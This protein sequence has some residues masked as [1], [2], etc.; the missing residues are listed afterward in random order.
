MVST[1]FAF[2]S[3]AIPYVNAQP[4]VGFAFEAVL[5]D[6]IARYWRARGRDVV[7]LSGTDDNSL[8]NVAAARARG[9][10]TQD[11]V[12]ENGDHFYALRAALELSYDDFVRTSSDLRHRSAV[13]KLWR[14]CA[15]NGDIYLQDYS[16]LYCAGCEQF[17]APEELIDGVCPEHGITPEQITEKNYFFRLSRYRDE[18][19]QRLQRG[20]LRIVPDHRHAE[21]V[22]FIGNGLLDFSISRSVE[23]AHGWG[24]PVPGD[25]S[26]VIYVWFDALTNYIAAL[27]YGDVNGKYPRLWANADRRTHVIGKGILRFHAVYWPAMLLSAGLEPPTTIFVH[28]YLTQEGRKISKSLGNAIDPTQ[29]IQRYGSDAVRYYLLGH[30]R[31]GE[32]GHFSLENL[33]R[34]HDADLADQYGNLVARTAGMIARWHDGAIPAP[35]AYEPSDEELI[36]HAWSLVRAVDADVEDFA[37]DRAVGRV[38]DFVGRANKYAVEQQPWALAKNP[39]RRSHE[40]LATV[41]YNLAEAIRISTAFA[42]PFIPHAAEKVARSFDLGAGWQHLTSASLSWAQTAPGS[43]PRQLGPLF[44]KESLT[45]SGGRQAGRRRA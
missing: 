10:P 13:T 21:I 16:G 7:F 44:P 5:A 40:R 25:G 45:T 37:I 35:L 29:L 42:A 23:R 24:I 18:L 3:T 41:V 8:K 28:G 31:T 39:D 2:I 43:R 32:D 6:S 11:L 20:T 27:G 9:I 19:L 34:A 4:H 14:A 38:W 22:R 26:Q 30:F 12:R 36:A 17:Y 15:D 33:V 1:S